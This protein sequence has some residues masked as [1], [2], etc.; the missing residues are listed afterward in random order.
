MFTSRLIPPIS[1]R[2]GWRSAC[3]GAAKPHGRWKLAFTLP[4]TAKALEVDAEFA[5]EG[6]G[7]QVGLRFQDPS[8]EVARS[9]AG[10]AGAEFSGRGEGRSASALPAYGFEF[11]RVLPGDQL[12]VSGFDARNVVD[13]SAAELN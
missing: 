3:R 12:A 4:G 9:V 1:A 11:G 7:K 8:P 10:M 6:T 5:W 13:A 2:V